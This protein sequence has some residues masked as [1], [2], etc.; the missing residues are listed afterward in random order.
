MQMPQVAAGFLRLLYQE[1][2][3]PQTKV[4]ITVKILENIA[5]REGGI[6]AIQSLPKALP[7]IFG[8]NVVGLADA[9]ATIKAWLIKACG[10]DPYS[11]TTR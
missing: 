6:Q 4:N 3:L 2:V 7:I 11:E 10:V 8:V 1:S 5:K 9:T